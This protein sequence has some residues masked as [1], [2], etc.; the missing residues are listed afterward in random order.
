MYSPSLKEANCPVCQATVAI[1]HR[2]QT[3]DRQMIS[4]LWFHHSLSKT[5]ARL[6]IIRAQ[7]VNSHG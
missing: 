5:K 2:L 4:H 3:L 7:A 1:T 6:M